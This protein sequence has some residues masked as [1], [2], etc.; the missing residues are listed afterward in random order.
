MKRAQRSGVKSQALGVNGGYIALISVLILGAIAVAITLSVI[1]LGL[2]S[3]RSSFSVQQGDQTKGLADLCI[4]E[5]LQ[6]IRNSSSYVG[7][8]TIVIGEGSCTYT[9]VNDGVQNRTIQASGTVDNITRRVLVTIDS[10]NPLIN[11]TSWQEVA[12]F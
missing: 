2:G 10:I 11:I 3:S 5:A 7:A 4:E 1:L 12:D 8:D 9:V 6:R